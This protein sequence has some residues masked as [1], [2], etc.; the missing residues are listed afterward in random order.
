M[1]ASYK[2]EVNKGERKSD[3]FYTRLSGHQWIRLPHLDLFG[4]NTEARSELLAFP[5][6]PHWEWGSS[7][8]KFF[9]LGNSDLF[10]PLKD[11]HTLRLPTSP[12]WAPVSSSG[13]YSHPNPQCTGW[14][15]SNILPYLWSHKFWDSNSI[16]SSKEGQINEG[17]SGQ[18][19][20]HGRDEPGR[21]CVGRREEVLFLF[22][23]P[24]NLTLM[25]G[26]LSEPTH[27]ARRISLQGVPAHLLT[28]GCHRV[29]PRERAKPQTKI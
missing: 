16:R 3:L 25:A 29:T 11:S 13:K 17:L 8:H 18:R 26:N 12:C 21:V 9:N 20:F 7:S 2:E 27:L 22:L 14:S 28:P 24:L 1:G 23:W 6:T 19:R 10:C 4:D 5:S 15:L